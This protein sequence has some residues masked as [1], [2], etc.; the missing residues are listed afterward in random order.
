MTSSQVVLANWPILATGYRLHLRLKRGA[1]R[2]RCAE[3]K[4]SSAAAH[5]II[6]SYCVM[7]LHSI[8][9]FTVGIFSFRSQPHLPFFVCAAPAP[10]WM[11]SLM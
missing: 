10:G 1:I 4:D 5:T 9:N 2:L 3:K 7:S 11:D 8:L 6:S